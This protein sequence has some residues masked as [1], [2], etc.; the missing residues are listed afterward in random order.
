[1]SDALNRHKGDRNVHKVTGVGGVLSRFE[2]PFYSLTHKLY[3]GAEPH[4]LVRSPLSNER[5]LE[6]TSPQHL[7][8]GG[9]MM[10]IQF[11]R[12]WRD[13]GPLGDVCPEGGFRLDEQGGSHETVYSIDRDLVGHRD[14]LYVGR[15]GPTGI[16]S[17]FRRYRSGWFAYIQFGAEGLS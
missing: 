11:D 7:V 4:L 2:V 17:G 1:M 13:P 12:C 3:L 16:C 9:R 15:G 6:P 10:R 5:R 14:G 8:A